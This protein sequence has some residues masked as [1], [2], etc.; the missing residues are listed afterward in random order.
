M[1]GLAITGIAGYGAHGP[2]HLGVWN[3][4]Y[5][6][7]RRTGPGSVP[8]AT[9]RSRLQ[10]L[11]GID[12][13]H[14]AR[15]VHVESTAGGLTILSEHVPGPTLSTLRAGGVGLDVAQGWRLLADLCAALA[16]LHERGIIHADVSPSNVLVRSE[17]PNRGRAVLVDVGGEEDWELG[18]VGFRAPEIATGA[19]ASRASDIWSAAR[20]A[21]W[22]V[23]DDHR[24]YFHEVLGHALQQNPEHRPGAGDLAAQAEAEAAAQIHIPDDARLASAHLRAKASSEPTTRASRR[25]SRTRARPHRRR[26]AVA[27]GAV[28]LAFLLGGYMLAEELFDSGGGHKGST[29]APAPETEPASRPAVPALPDPGDAVQELTDLRD[30]A[31]AT[32]DEDLLARVT[33]PES[34]AAESDRELLRRFRGSRPVG[35]VT[36]VEVREVTQGEAGPVVTAM[37]TQAEFTWEGGANDGITVAELPPRCARIHLSEVEREWFVHETSACAAAEISG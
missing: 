27:G 1:P 10:R 11:A 28:F 30:R 34:K 29:A 20:V 14:V 13:P 6:S 35:L 16:A 8:L 7:I 3:G 32:H 18:T 19:P 12:S 25:R 23:Q 2:I 37:L 24:L 36:A 31:L 26:H 22:A 5:V 33:I 21:V 4:T 15:V 17:Q 9:R